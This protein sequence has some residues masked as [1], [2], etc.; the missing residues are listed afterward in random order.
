MLLTNEV[1]KVTPSHV[2]T[3][4]LLKLWPFTVR[5]KPAPPAVALLGEIEDTDGVDGQEEQ[6]T[7]GSKS[8]ANAP[9]R[10]SDL[11]IVAIA[12]MG[13]PSGRSADGQSARTNSRGFSKSVVIHLIRGTHLIA[14]REQAALYML[15]RRSPSP[16][17]GGVFTTREAVTAAV[18]V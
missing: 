5:V 1:V 9:P 16:Y 4:L 13:V 14:S 3:E 7:A 15:V 2:A 6:E 18:P 17:E 10:R 8:I 12:A 11:F